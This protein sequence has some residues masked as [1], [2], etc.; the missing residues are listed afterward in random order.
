MA[1]IIRF[2]HTIYVYLLSYCHD[3]NLLFAKED[4]RGL[5]EAWPHAE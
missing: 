1:P 5:V 2:I 3:L 4:Y